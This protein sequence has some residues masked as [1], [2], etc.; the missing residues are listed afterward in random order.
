MRSA[1]F[2]LGLAFVAGP[3]LAANGA[4]LFTAQCKMCHQAKSGPMAPTLAGVAGAKIASRPGFT[5][6]AALKAKS[7]QTWTDANLDA[8]LAN[9][10]GFAPGTRMMVKVAA[11]ADRKALIGYLKTLK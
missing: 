7:T 3:A 10:A 4:Q 5:Y 8:Y 11:P 6:S 2:A 1:V 9:P